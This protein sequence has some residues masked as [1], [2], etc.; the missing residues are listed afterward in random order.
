M[1]RNILITLLLFSQLTYSQIRVGNWRDHFSYNSCFAVCQGGDR[2]YGATATGVFWYST[3]NGEI[4]KLCRVQ[5]LNDIDINSIEYSEQNH[6]LAI[7]YQNGNVDFVFQDRILNMPEIKDKLMQGGKRINGITFYNNLAFLSTD[8]GIVVIDLTKEE[9]KDTYFIGD[10][11]ES[12]RVNRVAIVNGTI[13][14][15]TEKGLLSANVDDPFLIQ[16]QRWTKETGFSNLNSECSDV[17][18]FGAY[19]VAIESNPAD[20]KDV[21]WAINVSTWVELG[22]QYNTVS[23]VRANSNK[24]FVT[25]LE[26]I[27][28]KSV[29]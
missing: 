2:I 13:Y 29:V 28:R 25:S 10:L 26:G 24:L 6:V 1:K 9:V 4:G 21:I 20:Q 14:A 12:L 19:V 8:F 11:G 17:E 23:H 3:A 18:A 7:G 5:G 15:A 16:Y 27:D 22:R